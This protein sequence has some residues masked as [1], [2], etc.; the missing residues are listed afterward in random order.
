[1]NDGVHTDEWCRNNTRPA[2]LSM[3]AHSAPLG[4]AFYKPNA[5]AN[6]SGSLPSSFSGD[7]F[8]PFHGS[9]NRNP[10][11]GYKVVRVPF[12]GGMPSGQPVDVMR[13]DDEERA[14]WPSGIRPVDAAFT[15][16]GHLLI[17]SDGTKNMLFNTYTEGQVFI[18]TAASADLCP[19]PSTANTGSTGS[20]GSTN[21]TGGTGSSGATNSSGTTSNT[22]QSG[23]QTAPNSSLT[24]LARQ[25]RA[26]LWLLGVAVCSAAARVGAAW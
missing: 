15:S 26:S 20:T 10:A 16:C 25:S 2:A 13:H 8:V 18:I 11:T 9:W 19:D 4:L 14:K 23:M 24:N 17:S 7:A 6:C 5:T 21:S 1:M 3:Q 22:G 12:H